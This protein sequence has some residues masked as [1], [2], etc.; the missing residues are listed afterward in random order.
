MTLINKLTLNTGIQLG[1]KLISLVFGLGVVALM[2]RALGQ[3]GFGQ[4]TTIIAFLQLAGIMV[5]LG[6]TV[7]CGK[8]IAQGVYSESKLLGNILSFRTITAVIVFSLAP[9]VAWFFPYPLI[10]KIG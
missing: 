2:T 10:I 7:T 3:E 6:L 4:Y 5:D 1:G 9:V 8:T